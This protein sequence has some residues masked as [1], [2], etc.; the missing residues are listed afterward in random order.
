MRRKLV[1][2]E[3]VVGKDHDTEARTPRLDEV[4]K[5]VRDSKGESFLDVGAELQVRLTAE[6]RDG[7]K[8]RARASIEA[9]GFGTF[10]M[11][12]DEGTSLGGDD[13]SPAPLAYFGAALAF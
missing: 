2:K 13:S 5:Y 10:Y 4:S 1:I 11:W 12:C 7:M 9:P 8:K 6:A 3:G